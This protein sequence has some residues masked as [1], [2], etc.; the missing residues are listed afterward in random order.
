VTVPA[1]PLDPRGDLDARRTDGQAPTVAALTGR[2]RPARLVREAV[3]LALTQ[4]VATC[5]AAL[6]TAAVCA[7]ILATTGQAAATE[8]RVVDSIGDAGA[9]TLVF[10]DPN[11]RAEIA[12]VGLDRI[13]ALPGV[14][15][16]IGLGPVVDV[17]VTALGDAGH[18][19]PAR[20]LFTALPPATQ[21]T[22]GRQPQAGEAV[23]G[24]EA[25]RQLQLSD[26]TGSVTG[27]G[28]RG[29]V[30]GS[31]AAA[32]PL[33]DYERFVL[34]RSDED[35]AQQLRRI[36]VVARSTQD[37]VVLER[38]VPALLQAR[39]RFE[40]V[41]ES[42]TALVELQAVVAGELGE[43]ARQLM[44]LV[45]S[46]GLV[47]IGITLYGATATRRRDFGRRR[48]LGASRSTIVVLVLL[49]TAFA[50]SIGA[51]LGTASGAAILR[52]TEGARPP[53][54]F[55]VG[56]AALAMLAALVAAVLPALSAAARDPVSILRVP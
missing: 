31:F 43:S 38:A 51:T 39:N 34:V 10:S 40:V 2:P 29:A 33:T 32:E 47:L 55:I 28:Y 21:L 42:P 9:R 56:V 49:H 14:E 24:D 16:V 8:R 46:A 53:G 30:V 37:V 5:V 45:L 7:V 27:D 19:V 22:G 44:L 36:Y 13:A 11:A 20:S 50:A 12:A 15:W 18:R 23:A 52:A 48:A 3:A 25:M 1:R 54:A 6:V 35:P 41:V 17:T 26:A 4:P